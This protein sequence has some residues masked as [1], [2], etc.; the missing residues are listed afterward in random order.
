MARRRFNAV[1]LIAVT[2]AIMTVARLAINRADK[3]RPGN[4]QGLNIRVTLCDD[5]ND[6]VQCQ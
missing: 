2:T 4:A 6:R 3:N 1:T 5:P